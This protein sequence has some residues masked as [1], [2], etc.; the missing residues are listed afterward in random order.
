MFLRRT[1]N[2]GRSLF[3]GTEGFAQAL[4]AAPRLGKPKTEQLRSFRS[5]DPTRD[6]RSGAQPT[7]SEIYDLL[8]YGNFDSSRL[9]RSQPSQSYAIGRSEYVRIAASA[10]E[11]KRSLIVDGRL[12]NGKTVFLHLLAAELTARKWACYLYRPGN[13]RILEELS[14]LSSID[15][16]VIFIEEYVAAQD[17]L[18]ELAAIPNSRI[19]IQLRTGTFDV[20]FN[21]IMGLIPAPVHRVTLRGL[22]PS[23]VSAFNQLCTTA[24][25]RPLPATT[26][27]ASD[28]RD[29]LLDVLKSQSIRYRVKVALEPLFTNR[30]TRRILTFTMLI[31]FHKGSVTADF[32]RFVAKD[33]P[34]IVLKPHEELSKEIFENSAEFFRIRSSIFSEFVIQNFL[35][36]EEVAEAVVE[37]VLAAS[38]RR[39]QRP[40]RVLMSN[41]MAYQRLYQL[42]RHTQRHAPLIIPIYERLRRDTLVNAEPL[43][44]LQYAIVMADQKRLDAAEEYIQTAYRRA[45]EIQ[46]FRTYQ[47]DT[48]AFRIS[49]MH[50]ASEPTGSE[51]SNMDAILDGFGRINSMLG[52]GNHRSYAVRVL[53]SVRPFVLA[54]RADMSSVERQAVRTLIRQLA[55]TLGAL[56]SDWKAETGSEAVRIQ[57]IEMDSMLL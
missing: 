39:N 3:I 57:L 47:I 8:V 20:R 56:S 10:L 38:T 53:E 27:A 52:D 43:F 14:T 49:L 37:I 35:S 15:R 9:A 17:V 29:L 2:Y 45:A 12:G 31:A 48:Q 28:L 6:R 18:R 24:G 44:W 42:F 36:P 40:Y 23:E 1:A 41:L 46:G 13:P 5:L 25:I 34:F 21:E 11:I 16:L 32:I 54:R 26:T 7:A 33:D 22:S 30:S 51:I 19:V 55:E 50:A 4:K